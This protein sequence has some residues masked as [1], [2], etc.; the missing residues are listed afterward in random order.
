MKDKDLTIKVRDNLIM[1]TQVVGDAP[2]MFLTIDKNR[3]YLREWLTWV[4][5]TVTVED[6]EL[7]IKKTQGIDKDAKDIILGILF[8]NIHVGNL[9]IHNIDRRRDSAMIGYLLAENYQGKGIMTDCVKA[10]VNYCFG[11]LNLNSIHISCAESNKK[12]RAVPERL[13]FIQEG[14]LQDGL[15]YHGIYHNEVVYGIVKRNWNG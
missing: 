10:A 5:N 2:Q 8:D 14:I 1:R 12:S 9:G 15:K 13:N 4:D 11:G 6:I 3:K 7:S